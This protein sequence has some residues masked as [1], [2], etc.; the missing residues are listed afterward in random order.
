MGIVSDRIAQRK[1]KLGMLRPEDRLPPMVPGALI[2][3]LGLFW[4]GWS[5]QAHTFWLVPLLGTAVLGLGLIATFIPVQMYLIDAF[6]VHAA[7]AVAAL[8]V[9][10][11]VVGAVLPLA[12]QKMYDALGNGWGNSLLAFIALAL[13]P[14]PFLFL[15]FGQRLRENS[16]YRGQ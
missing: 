5:V 13:V 2:I 8:V 3:P 12:G 15:R 14:V 4:Y 1:S 16:H 7:S 10:R 11:S 6:T 9:L